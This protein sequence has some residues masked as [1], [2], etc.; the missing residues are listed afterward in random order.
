MRRHSWRSSTV[1][2]PT[3]ALGLPVDRTAAAA[4]GGAR[5]KPAPLDGIRVVDCS[6]VLAGPYATMLLADLGASV[7]KVEPPEG[8]PTRGWGPPWVGEGER[9]CRCVL[10]VGQSRQ[11]ID[12][13]GPA[14]GRRAR[15]AVA[16][17]RGRGRAGREPPGR[18]VRAAR[19]HG[20]GAGSPAPRARPPRDLGL[21]ALGRGRLEA[22][23]R[24]RRP[25][26]RGADVDH[27]L[28]GRGGRAP[29]QGRR[30]GL[31]RGRRSPW[32]R[33][34]ACRPARSDGRDRAAGRA[35]GGRLAA[36]V[37]AVA[38]REPG[39]ERVH[40]RAAADPARQRAPEHR[41][42]RGVRGIR[43]ADRDR[44]GQRAPVAADVRGAGPAGVSRSIR[45][46][47][48]T[49]IASSIATS[50]GPSCARAF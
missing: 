29:E 35:T 32:L 23:L 16:A 50:C 10:P 3:G 30:R 21:R 8:D 18:R 1:A 37:D 9:A 31:R 15:R 28:P 6:T 19:V 22:R 44:G 7:I 36:R 17:D 12:P 48:P 49:P 14:D 33:R 20:R 47:R 5:L 40:H 26:G 38:A 46:S 25:G 41:A 43:P 27:G 39:P 42:V 24:L 34:G 45:G 11:A 2:P 4:R 13:A